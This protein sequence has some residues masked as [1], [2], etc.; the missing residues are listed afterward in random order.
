MEHYFHLYAVFQ[1]L[2]EST[3]MRSTRLNWTLK[4]S[5]LF[6][7]LY[8]QNK[9]RFI[10][11]SCCSFP[12]MKINIY[13][14]WY[15]TTIL[16]IC[17]SWC[18]IISFVNIWVIEFRNRTDC[19]CMEKYHNGTYTIIRLLGLLQLDGHNLS[20]M[21]FMK[22]ATV[23]SFYINCVYPWPVITQ[24]PLIGFVLSC[25][26]RRWNQPCQSSSGRTICY[27]Q[28]EC[29]GI[30]SSRCRHWACVY[31]QKV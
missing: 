30:R 17:F 14:R 15:H 19:I 10:G 21:K 25:S 20:I 23:K 28:C 1:Q 29:F 5:H 26:T 24:G 31:I 8:I 6:S 18:V 27:C 13:P 16:L 7:N 11:M 9:K 12:P 3:D 22:I 2:I 4:D